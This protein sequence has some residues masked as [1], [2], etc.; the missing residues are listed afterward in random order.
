[1]HPKRDLL[2]ILKGWK[3]GL[4]EKWLLSICRTLD[5][6]RKLVI[7]GGNEK[8]F[9]WI[10]QSPL[11]VESHIAVWKCSIKIDTAT[12]VAIEIRLGYIFMLL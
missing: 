1:V 6:S 7:A 9:N 5:L 4:E 12:K 2:L 11:E 3:K 10:L 8:L